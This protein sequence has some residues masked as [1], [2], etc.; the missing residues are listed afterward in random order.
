[1]LSRVWRGVLKAA[2]Y[3]LGVVG[4]DADLVVVPQAPE[5]LAL[6]EEE[7]GEMRRPGSGTAQ[8]D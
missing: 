5:L 1:M 4:A 6:C 8:R 7:V 2:L 3:R